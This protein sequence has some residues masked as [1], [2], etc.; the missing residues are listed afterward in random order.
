MASVGPALARP[1]PLCR[2]QRLREG[3][4][5]SIW[6]YRDWVIKALNADMPFDRVHG[7]ADWPATCCRT[8]RRSA[9]RHRFSSQHDAQRGGGDRSAGISLL[10]AGRSGQHHGTAWLGLT[11][12]CA[13]CHTHKFDPITHADYYRFMAFLN[14][15]DEPQMEVPNA[16]VT[17]KRQE[18]AAQIAAARGD[19]GPSGSPSR[20]SAPRHRG[21]RAS[22]RPPGRPSSS[23]MTARRNS[24]A[25]LPS[26]IST[27][28]SRQQP[29]QCDGRADRSDGRF[30]APQRRAGTNTARQF[31][32]ERDRSRPE[33]ARRQRAGRAVEI[34]RRPGRFFARRLSGG[35]RPGRQSG[36]RLGRSRAG[37]ME[38]QPHGDLHALP[39]GRV[40]RR[41]SLD[42]PAAVRNSAAGTPWPGAGRFDSNDRRRPPAAGPRRSSRALPP[43]WPNRDRK[44]PS[45]PSCIRNRPW[46]TSRF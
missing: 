18:M 32:A 43:G 35:Q 11:L 42:D 1:G 22:Y 5:A 40:C 27:R 44:R 6:P 41:R 10:F 19:A 13:Q 45:G 31:R 8:P 34:H 46:P 25:P 26:R 17:A 2:H 16:D 30:V 7:R 33:P 21:R 37:Q 20:N 39:A 38:R 23:S 36:N 24:P 3:P 9:D 28:W 29:D 14:N 12:G 4:P 15:A